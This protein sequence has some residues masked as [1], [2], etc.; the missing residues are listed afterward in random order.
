MSS[1]RSNKSPYII[2][3][4]FIIIIIVRSVYQQLGE[5]QR[6]QIRE[7]REYLTALLDAILILCKQ[8]LA[9]RGHREGKESENKG[10]FLE[11]LDL[12]SKRDLDFK[13]RYESRPGNASYTHPEIQNKLTDA[14]AQAILCKNKGELS[15]SEAEHWAPMVDEMQD[16]SC[17][18]LMAICIRHA[19]SC[20]VILLMRGALVLTLLRL[21]S[22]MHHLLQI[23]FTPSSMGLDPSKAIAQCYNGTAAMS[24][25]KSGV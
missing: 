2:E 7:N 18:E 21:K 12:L 16:C 11:L 10:N 4:T 1:I 3:S 14:S 5:S 22:W 15:D 17:K 13:K 6:S 9:L 19:V 25:V 8:D 24:G 20:I 23:L